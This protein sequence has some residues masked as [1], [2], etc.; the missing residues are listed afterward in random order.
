LADASARAKAVALLRGEI[1]GWQQVI[2]DP[3]LGAQ[4][5]V[6]VYGKD[7]GLAKAEQQESSAATNALMESDVTR[8]HGLFWM[9]PETIGETIATLAV[10]KI[11]ATPDMFSNELLQDAYQGHTRL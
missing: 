7:L 8:Q 5:T 10:G 3:A 6:D 11:K 2:A 1:R 4:L 9:T